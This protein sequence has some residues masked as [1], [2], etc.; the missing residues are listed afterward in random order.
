MVEFVMIGKGCT[1]C[2]AD[3]KSLTSA[4][5]Y[6][7]GALE[8]FRP[9]LMAGV[10]KIWDVLR[11]GLAAKVESFP[12][13]ARFLVGTALDWKKFAARVGLTTPLV[14]ALVVRKFRS[15]VGGRLRMALSAGGPLSCDVQ[16]FIRAA[17]GIQLFQGYVSAPFI[18]YFSLVFGE[19]RCLLA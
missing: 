14:D 2:Y 19:W 10:P 15:A 18:V 16:D 3:P 11:K 13:A 5:S 6:P 12:R 7:Q 9:T 1:L 17:L 8:A 4:G